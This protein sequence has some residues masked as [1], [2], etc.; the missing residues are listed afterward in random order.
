MNVCSACQACMNGAGVAHAK[1]SH[2]AVSASQQS[3]RGARSRWCASCSSR[4]PTSPCSGPRWWWCA[5]ARARS[6]GTA[7]SPCPSAQVAQGCENAV[8]ARSK[9]TFHACHTS[10]SFCC[11]ASA[12]QGQQR[13]ATR[14]AGQERKH[15]CAVRAR[16]VCQ[17]GRWA[18]QPVGTVRHAPD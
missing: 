15:G 12:Q 9:P 7:H 10:G 18:I 3:S 13:G 11:S 5:A 1:P 6:P 2:R 16:C 17:G 4:R 14:V 8:L